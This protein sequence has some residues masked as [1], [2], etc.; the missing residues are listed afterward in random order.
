MGCPTVTGKSHGM[1]HLASLKIILFIL[2]SGVISGGSSHYMSQAKTVRAGYSMK[3]DESDG[4]LHFVATQIFIYLRFETHQNT[5]KCSQMASNQLDTLKWLRKLLQLTETL[6]LIHLMK[7]F[8]SNLL[9][10][11]KHHKNIF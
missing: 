4:S 3:G 2:I 9:D 11:L 7:L 8:K 1:P 5:S 10:Y 6:I